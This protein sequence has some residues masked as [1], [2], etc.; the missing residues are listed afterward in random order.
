MPI[1]QVMKIHQLHCK[2]NYIK[3][4]GPWIARKGEKRKGRDF[5]LNLRFNELQNGPIKI[6]LFV[7]SHPFPSLLAIQIRE[8]VL[9]SS[10]TIQRAV[11][12]MFRVQYVCFFD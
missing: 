12:F 5:S 9:F 1:V 2:P 7:Y 3:L 8:R 10:L 4:T 6:H 11:A